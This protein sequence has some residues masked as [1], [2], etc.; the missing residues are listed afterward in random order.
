ME[1]YE[2][3]NFVD[4]VLIGYAT[5]KT[6]NRTKIIVPGQYHK[7]IDQK[8][9]CQNGIAWAQRWC[10]SNYHIKRNDDYCR[11]KICNFEYITRMWVWYIS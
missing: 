5:C 6:Q 1:I 9:M 10:V 3:Y 11:E 2:V 7:Q 4:V 8:Q